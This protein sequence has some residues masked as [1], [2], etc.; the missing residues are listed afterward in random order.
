MIVSAITH[1]DGGNKIE[2]KNAYG[3]VRS[4]MMSKAIDRSITKKYLQKR[5]VHCG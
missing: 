1:L 5:R 4:D 2:I 3:R